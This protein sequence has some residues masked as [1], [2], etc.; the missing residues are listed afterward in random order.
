LI[1]SIAL[2]SFYIQITEASRD[3]GGDY[4]ESASRSG[5]RGV[6]PA[7]KRLQIGERW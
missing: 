7:A 2:L 4:R 6:F 1:F 5:H 3:G